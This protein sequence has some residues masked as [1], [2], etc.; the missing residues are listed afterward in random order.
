VTFCLLAR[1]RGGKQCMRALQ[2]VYLRRPRFALQL[3][4]L[5]QITPV[6]FL[7]FYIIVNNV[8]AVYTIQLQ[9]QQQQ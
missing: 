9:Q 2:S 5:I 1:S 8:Y 4:E 6:Y 7:Q 3:F